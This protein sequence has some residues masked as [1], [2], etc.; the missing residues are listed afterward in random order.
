MKDHL[1]ITDINLSV[2]K[3]MLICKITHLDAWIM[4]DSFYCLF[5]VVEELSSAM[6]EV[7]RP[8]A[9]LAWYRN[10]PLLLSESS[11]S[12]SSELKRTCCLFLK[13]FGWDSI[14]PHRLE[15]WLNT[16]S[17]SQ[18]WCKRSHH[19]T[20]VLK[21]ASRRLNKRFFLHL[22]HLACPWSAHSA[23]SAAPLLITLFGALQRSFSIS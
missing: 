16:S 14:F 13:T 12:S 20:T 19:Y 10:F 15:L 18:V 5:E 17:S 23:L 4:C 3:I 8:I 7:W 9:R 6:C 1:H 22:W 21:K 2:I 11:L